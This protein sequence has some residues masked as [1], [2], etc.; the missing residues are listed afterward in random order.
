M[1]KIAYAHGNCPWVAV[2]PN[3]M[4][5]IYFGPA[6]KYAPA[7][8]NFR[9]L[10]YRVD[11]VDG[12]IARLKEMNGNGPTGIKTYGLTPQNSRITNVVREAMSFKM[13]SEHIR[14]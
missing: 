10:P 12:L 13:A 9:N 7:L 14:A 6:D 11:S 2:K 8:Q 1:G 3:S 5:M 4:P